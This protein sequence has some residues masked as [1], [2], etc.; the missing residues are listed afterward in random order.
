ML[1]ALG[2]IAGVL[3][4]FTY[5][6]YI[7]DIFRLKTKPQRATWFI[8]SV[9]SGIALFAQIAKGASNSLWLIGVQTIGVIFIFALSIRFGTGGFT[10]RDIIALVAAGFGL[11]LWFYTKEAALALFISIIIDAIGGLLTVAKAYKDPASETLATWLLSG[12]AGIFAAFAVGSFNYVLLAFPVYVVLINYAV[13][14][15]M[16][17]GKKRLTSDH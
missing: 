14:V 13:A 5:L 11:L 1:R 16:V 10:R 6:P 7:R 9:L 4:V 17:L 8:W 15:A 2:L 12:T 3:S